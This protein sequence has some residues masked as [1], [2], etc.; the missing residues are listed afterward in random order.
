[1]KFKVDSGL[2]ILRRPVA[3][4][5]ALLPIGALVVSYGIVQWTFRMVANAHLMNPELAMTVE[6]YA[7][8]FR[9]YAIP[10]LVLSVVLAVVNLW[11][12]FSV[13]PRV[14]AAA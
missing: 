10:V 3:L 1:M 6:G 14:C 5:L 9:D 8:F 7:T 12:A 2:E 13:R 4:M 11:C